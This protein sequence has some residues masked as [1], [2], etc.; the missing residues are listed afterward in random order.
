MAAAASGRIE[1]TAVSILSWRVLCS[2]NIAGRGLT[3]A[4]P[5]GYSLQ[6]R[7]CFRDCIHLSVENEL[8]NDLDRKSLE[9][10]NLQLDMSYG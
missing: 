5:D 4:L 8:N 7:L 3:S 1:W 2:S 9:I 6:K 10:Y